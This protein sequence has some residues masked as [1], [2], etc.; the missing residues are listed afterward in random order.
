MLEAYQ[1]V[2]G[3]SSSAGLDWRDVEWCCCAVY[4][5]GVGRGL[6]TCWAGHPRVHALHAE[7]TP[8]RTYGVAASCGA[9]CCMCPGVGRVW[10][11][12]TMHVG[13]GCLGISLITPLGGHVL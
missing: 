12:V 7:D 6:G 9:P 10:G 2:R 1:K 5:T 11:E 13:S 3:G 8:A 4:V